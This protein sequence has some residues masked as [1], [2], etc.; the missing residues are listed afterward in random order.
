LGVAGGKKKSKPEP[1]P[2]SKK[3]RRA[4]Q[5]TRQSKII[6]IGDRCTNPVGGEGKLEEEYQFEPRARRPE[7]KK[8]LAQTERKLRRAEKTGLLPQI[9]GWKRRDDR[10][11]PGT[12]PASCRR[13]TTIVNEK[14]RGV[15]SN[16]ADWKNLY[17]QGN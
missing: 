14:V 10:G 3:F 1:E 4:G 13:K 6:P 11:T 5:I 7:K 17:I 12:V 2:W 15:A 9:L 16:E 8:G